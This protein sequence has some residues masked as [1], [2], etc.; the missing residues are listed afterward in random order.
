MTTEQQPE[1]GR[2]VEYTDAYGKQ[3]PCLILKVYGHPDDHPMMRVFDSSD[4]GR[5]VR[6]P[7]DP[8]GGTNTWRFYPHQLNQ[9][10]V[11]SAVM[12]Q[13][14]KLVAGGHLQ[15]VGPN[16]P[17]QGMVQ[18]PGSEE[19]MPLTIHEV[20]AW[21]LSHA[22]TRVFNSLPKAGG[23]ITLPDQVLEFK[24]TLPDV[25]NGV[26]FKGGEGTRFQPVTD[27]EPNNG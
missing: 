23:T 11:M 5:I 4:Y 26:V 19:V 1:A 17:Q 16:E 27:R 20:R 2:M 10:R 6:P 9:A 21:G 7:H 12:A 8:N 18:K 22:L 24:G 14:E 25:P 13:V 3:W 15:G